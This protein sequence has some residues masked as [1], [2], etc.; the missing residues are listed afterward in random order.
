MSIFTTNVT[1]SPE[2]NLERYKPKV[3]VLLRATA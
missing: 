2:K 3:A 1:H